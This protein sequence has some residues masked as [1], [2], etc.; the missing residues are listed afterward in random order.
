MRAILESRFAKA[1]GTA[2]KDGIMTATLDPSF[3]SVSL[4]ELALLAAMMAGAVA[5]A[6]VGWLCKR[7]IGLALCTFMIGIMGGLLFGTWMGRW[8]YVSSE[9]AGAFVRAGA[10][11]FGSAVLAGLAGSVPTAFFIP[12]VVIFIAL[13]HVRNRPPRVKTGLIAAAAGVAA[14]VLT[15]VVLLFV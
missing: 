13:R 11:S 10:G 3:E 15:A 9:G 2:G 6:L 12:A 14:G 7:N 8:C 4:V 1:R 5:G